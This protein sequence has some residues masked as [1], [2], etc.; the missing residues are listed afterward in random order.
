MNR[1]CDLLILLQDSA[2]E[3][4]TRADTARTEAAALRKRV[5]GAR[6]LAA[7]SVLLNGALLAMF[8]LR[9]LA[10]L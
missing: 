5:G 9:R 1:M 6:R 3:A 2:R 10:R 7:S 8:L 4:E